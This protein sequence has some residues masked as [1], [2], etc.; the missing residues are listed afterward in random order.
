MDA[1]AFTEDF[2]LKEV[3][4][5]KAAGIKLHLLAA[6]AHGIEVCGALMDDKPYKAKGLGRKRFNSVLTELFPEVYAKANSQIA[7]YGQL[8]NHLSHC[9]IPAK[10]IRVETSDSQNHLSIKNGMLTIDLDIFYEDYRA[11][12]KSVLAKMNTGELES[13]R[14]VLANMNFTL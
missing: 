10:N 2:L 14:I 6:I 9:M 8:R 12:V 13:K 11:A 1:K 3:E 7:L 4:Q 5:M